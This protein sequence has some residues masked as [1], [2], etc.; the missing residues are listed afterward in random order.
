MSKVI[1]R[2][3]L[4]AFKAGHPARSREF[5]DEE[6]S[7]YLLDKIINENCH[8]SKKLLAYIAK[9]NNEYHKDFFKNTEEPLHKK[10]HLTD[11][12]VQ[13]GKNKNKLIS[14]R[15]SCSDRKNS[16][17]RDILSIERK[18]IQSIEPLLMH[19]DDGIGYFDLHLNRSRDL[20]HESH[21]IELIDLS[22][23][24]QEA[25]KN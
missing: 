8:E 13:T 1:P 7:F 19:N 25:I 5:I 3:Y 4:G 10:T 20:N 12:R 22:I 23:E 17:N 18:D 2:E 24:S 6:Y 21:L 9:F 16:R 14:H 11:E 15:K